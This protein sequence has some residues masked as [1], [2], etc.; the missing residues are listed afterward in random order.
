MEASD[1]TDW[2]M[3]RVETRGDGSELLGLSLTASGPSLLLIK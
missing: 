2:Q 1:A 3:F